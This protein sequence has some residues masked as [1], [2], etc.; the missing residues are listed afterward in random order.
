VRGIL[1]D[2]LPG[3]NWKVTWHQDL[4]I[5]VKER[6]ELPGYGPWSVKEG[7]PHVQPPIEVL[8]KMLTLRLHLDDCFVDNGPVRVLAKTHDM[9]LLDTAKI[10]ALRQQ[11]PEIPATTSAGGILLMRP[12]LLHA[13]SAAVAP[14]HRRV[15]HIE[16]AQSELPP[17]LKWNAA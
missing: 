8:K 13:S 5:A 16:Y 17:P 2:K 10:A 6:H 9:G 12:L 11:L 3:A 7:V 14:K 15:I 4:S 1:F